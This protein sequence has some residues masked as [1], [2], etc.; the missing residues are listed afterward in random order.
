[1]KQRFATP[2]A[3]G[4]YNTMASCRSDVIGGINLSNREMNDRLSADS[5][6]ANSLS[7]ESNGAAATFEYVVSASPNRTLP[8]NSKTRLAYLIIQNISVA[9][10]F[11]N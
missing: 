6:R 8:R 11:N 9:V 5:G 4:C 3:Y 1:M 10:F 7:D 2:Q